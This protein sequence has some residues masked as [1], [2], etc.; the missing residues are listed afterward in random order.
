M[1]DRDERVAADE[2]DDALVTNASDHRQLK[3]ARKTEK[4]QRDDELNDLRVLIGTPEGRR[5][6]WRVLNRCHIFESAFND[7]AVTMA[8]LVG[9][10]NVGKFLLAEIIE[11]DP[12]ALMLLMSENKLRN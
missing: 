7:N 5:F 10:D 11:A 8:F 3:K 6:L 1:A 9:E 4:N 12:R 2:D